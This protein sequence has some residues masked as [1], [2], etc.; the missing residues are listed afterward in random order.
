MSEVMLGSSV[1]S[2]VCQIMSPFG[3]A[4]AGAVVSRIGLSQTMAMAGIFVIAASPLLLSVPGFSRFCRLPPEHAQGF[5]R[6]EFP[7]AFR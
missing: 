5:F 6:R 3:T 2:F 1:T 7:Q 4:V